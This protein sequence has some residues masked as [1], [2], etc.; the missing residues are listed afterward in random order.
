VVCLGAL[1]WF[2]RYSLR[3]G[4]VDDAQLRVEECVR[5]ASGT[6]MAP[7]QGARYRTSCQELHFGSAPNEGS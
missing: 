5:R 7:G 4:A 3:P 2:F 1:A 6:H